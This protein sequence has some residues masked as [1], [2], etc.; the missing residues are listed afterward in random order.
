MY[1]FKIRATGKEIF[2]DDRALSKL[3]YR[4]STSK[5]RDFI[6]CP[7]Y[8]YFYWVIGLQR[9]KHFAIMPKPRTVYGTVI[10][11]V[12][13]RFF[14]KKIKN[15]YSSPDAL[16]NLFSGLWHAFAKGEEFAGFSPDWSWPEID[17]DHPNQFWVLKEQGR[18]ICKTFWRQ[19][20]CYF[21]D[22]QYIRPEVE[23]SLNDPNFGPKGRFHLTGKIDRLEFK[24]D[25]AC[26]IDYKTGN[27]YHYSEEYLKK[28]IQFT[29]YQWLYSLTLR[30]GIRKI[31]LIGMKL[32][33][34]KEGEDRPLNIER[35]KNV[36]LRSANEVSA[37]EKL[38][39]DTQKRL[40][41]Y[42]SGGDFP[43]SPGNH[44]YYL[45]PF[46]AECSVYLRKYRLNRRFEILNNKPDK[47]ISLVGERNFFS[48]PPPG[49]QLRLKLKLK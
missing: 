1:Y 29:I 26:I 30:N 41:A 47:D 38:I 48:P 7:L 34:L 35:L 44:C 10:H 15:G 21:Q 27:S 14:S 20:I 24:T 6:M 19:N 23:I 45:C 40:E 12:L 36:P 11:K 43:A 25:G 32:Y 8:F 3:Y 37:I 5:L 13:Y 17:F 31:P 33:F 22:Q 28:D 18:E 49:K 42:L 46:E 2:L 16:A 39:V 9:E 4:W